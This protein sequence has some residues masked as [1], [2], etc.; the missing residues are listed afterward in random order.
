MAEI[1][2]DQLALGQADMSSF[3]GKRSVRGGFGQHRTFA[4]SA[5]TRPARVAVL[6]GQVLVPAAGEAGRAHRMQAVG[7]AQAIGQRTGMTCRALDDLAG[8][9]LQLNGRQVVV[10]DRVAAFGLHRPFG[11]GA[12]VAG[13]AEQTGMAF[14]EAIENPVAVG[15]V[16]REPFVGRHDGCGIGRVV[17]A[18][19][20]QQSNAVPGLDHL[21]VRLAQV[22]HGVSRVAGLA[23]RHGGPGHPFCQI[24][25]GRKWL[26][27]RKVP[28][29]V[30]SDLLHTPVAIL[31]NESAAE[32]GPA[33]ALGFASGMALITALVEF[34]RYKAVHRRL[35]RG[36]VDPPGVVG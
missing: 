23:G 8:V 17:G 4:V 19:G 30:V 18:V 28:G 25:A 26:T 3:S 24:G 20:L 29:K 34:V 27:D 16:F 10:G 6:A 14:A 5:V 33:Q 36:R 15:I 2:A 12:A 1:A 7:T 21:G 35:S 9:A 22:V 13:L 31:A 11:V 32:H